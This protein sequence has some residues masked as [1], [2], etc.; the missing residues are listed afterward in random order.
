MS[1]IIF[2]FHG[3][4]TY[5]DDDIHL[6]PLKIG[7]MYQFLQ[8]EIEGFGHTF[9]P[10]SYNSSMDLEDC[11]AMA[12][13]Q[14]QSQLSQFPEEKVHFLGH[15]MGGLVARALL[16]SSE[17]K[18]QVSSLITFGTPHFGSQVAQVALEDKK[19]WTYL[20]PLIPP[21]KKKIFAQLAP[22]SISEFNQKYPEINDFSYSCALCSV[23][24]AALSWPLYLLQKWLGCNFLSDGLVQEESQEYG[25]VLGRFK[26][27]HLG[28]IGVFLQLTSTARKQ[29]RNEFLRLQLTF[30]A[31]GES[32]SEAQQFFELAQ[33]LLPKFSQFSFDRDSLDQLSDPV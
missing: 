4:N 25:N 15:S 18:K 20:K 31:L 7:K 19:T 11:I 24:L 22:D 3:L 2:Y 13:K 9:I 28:Q 32:F 17:I 10:I 5:G 26:V 21:H 29:A 16:H 27:D 8:K 14:T 33:L 6:G 30:Q 23:P 1:K 12:K